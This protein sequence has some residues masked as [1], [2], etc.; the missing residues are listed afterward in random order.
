MRRLLLVLALVACG[1]VEGPGPPPPPGPPAPPPPPPPPPPAPWAYRAP[2][3]RGDGL[4]GAFAAARGLDT[5]RTSSLIRS[6]L[7]GA[8][9]NIHAILIY[10]LGDLVLEEYFPGT[11]RFDGQFRTYTADSLHELYSVS[12][13]VTSA[14]VGIALASGAIPTLDTRIAPTIPDYA[15]QTA[16]D[17]S[18]LTFRH[19]LTMSA[20]LAWDESSTDYTDPA[21]DHRKM[22]ASP[23]PLTYLVTRPKAANPGV[24]FVYNSGLTHLLGELVK[25]RVNQ[26]LDGYA[27]TR[28]FQPLGITQYFWYRYPNG[29]THAGGGLFL[30][31]RDMMKF[32]VL[33]A[34]FGSWQGR[35]V[36]DSAWVAQSTRAQAPG[37]GGYGYQWWID[38]WTVNGRTISGYSAQ[39]IGGQYVF[40]VPSLDLVV[41]FTG[42]QPAAQQLLPFQLMRNYVLPAVR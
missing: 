29:V 38:S 8:T 28:V 22:D 19:L 2:V 20:G 14:A 6:V 9:P 33:Y 26:S 15:S 25:R 16:T 30:R 39:G 21:N 42:N 5:A 4:G 1:Q 18:T 7:S 3:D 27:A 23:D 31:P 34:R 24:R 37:A 32:G 41:V 12:K 10:R 36:I 11:A 35:R 13:S 17:L 40:V